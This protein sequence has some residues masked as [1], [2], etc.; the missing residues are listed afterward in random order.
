ML[1]LPAWAQQSGAFKLAQIKV[2]G[3]ERF[4]AEQII[5]ASG[6]HLGQTIRESDIQAAVN[7]LGKT[8]AFTEVSYEFR[9]DAD[10]MTVKLK[11]HETTT[12]LRCDFDNFVWFSDEDLTAAISKALP[13]FDGFLPEE[14]EMAQG[15]ADALQR[16][17]EAEKI[18]GRVSFMRAGRLG[19]AATA[20]VFH[21]DGNE[22]IVD[23][24]EVIRGPLEQSLF[25]ASSKR[26]VEKPYSRAF[27]RDVAGQELTA[28]EGNIYDLTY[29][30][31]FAKDEL[32][33]ILRA[34]GTLPHTTTLK[35]VPDALNLRVNVQLSAE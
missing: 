6:L 15:T 9:T 32:G 4:P 28:K 22:P 26:F 7:Q 23:S 11:M 20:Y 10:R 21:V 29:E 30:K 13:L 17:L 19:G 34:A 24:T 8:G 18:P 14:G 16:V 5:A 33:Q 1:V 2:L 3:A 35:R 25:A 12:F 31:R 27:A